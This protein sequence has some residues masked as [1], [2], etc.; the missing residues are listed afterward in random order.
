[1]A[2]GVWAVGGEALHWAGVVNLP[3]MMTP[4]LGWSMFF[5]LGVAYF[6]TAYLVLGSIFLAIGAMA[7]TVREIQT[8]NM[9]VTMAQ[10]LVFFF[11]SYALARQGT[12]VEYLAIAVPFSSPFAMLGRAATHEELWPHAVALGW[13]ALWVAVFV[14]AGAAMFR[15]LVMKSGPAGVSTGK[16]RFWR[17]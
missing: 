15:K 17:T 7:N 2:I 9:P 1:M 11:A 3:P 14:K 4:A 13:Q 5:A 8:L 6:A 10:L 12:T 16:K